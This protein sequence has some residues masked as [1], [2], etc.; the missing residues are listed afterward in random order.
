MTVMIDN[1]LLEELVT[2]FEVKTLAKTAEK[3]MVTQPTVT[4]GMQKLEEQLGVSLFDRKPNKITL[5]PTGELA[6]K[7][8]KKLLVAQ[9]AFYEQIRTFDKN[10]QKLRI[11]STA[12]G[13]LIL[14]EF[15]Q[16]DFPLMLDDKFIDYTEIEQR[17]ENEEFSLV[18][19]EHEIQTDTIE[20][21]YVGYEQ[22]YVNVDQFTYLAGK[23]QVGFKELADLSFI[24]LSDIGAWK[25]I[26]QDNIP[27]AKF[28]YQRQ[29]EALL[30][31]TR[32]SNFPY[33]TTNI[34]QKT[35]YRQ[36]LDDQG[37]VCL[38]ITDEAAKLP[39]YLTYLKKNKSKLQPFIKKYQE[40]W[41]AK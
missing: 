29:Q 10:Q 38:S 22:L 21:L 12:P 4:R 6:A 14:A 18:I 2:F 31:I 26:I 7:E 9:K 41:P 13:P 40:L 3:L 33:F 11:T 23:Q 5:T 25:K 19:S 36:I 37:R 15:L 32:Y 1:Y 20:S 8:A 24:V 34:T 28:L 17:L 39:F 27:D 35:P 16:N 30:E